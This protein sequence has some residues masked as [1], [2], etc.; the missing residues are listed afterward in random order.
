MGSKTPKVAGSTGNVINTAEIIDH[1][2]D[3]QDVNKNI[4]LIVGLVTASSSDP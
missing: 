2:A 1:K 4:N 3:I